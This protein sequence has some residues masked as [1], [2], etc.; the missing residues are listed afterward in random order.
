MRVDTQ[1]KLF[2]GVRID[3]RM[4]EQLEKCPPR[5]RV[6]FEA[7]DGKYLTVLRGVEETYI[8]K[9]LPAATELRT[10]DD[11]RRNIWSILQR[12]CPGRR[13][14]GEVKLF[15]LTDDEP[16]FT[17]QKRPGSP[18]ESGGSD[19]GAGHGLGLGLGKDRGHGAGLGRAGGHRGDPG[20]D[21]GPG[22]GPG[23][24]SDGD[25]DDYY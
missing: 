10:I 1:R 12:I 5:D 15:T 2:A 25:Q 23:P 18:G 20:T 13:D 16:T 21:P 19:S 22:P 7:E 6:F 9:V 14:E 8:G 17:G 4:R 24:G 3:S 11:I